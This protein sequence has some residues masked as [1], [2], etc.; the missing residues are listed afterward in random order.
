V[1]IKISTWL[2]CPTFKGFQAGMNDTWTPHLVVVA[3]GSW[4]FPLLFLSTVSDAVVRLFFRL[5][6]ALSAMS[7]L[8]EAARSLGF[9][10]GSALSS[11]IAI[12]RCTWVLDT[13]PFFLF[14]CRYLYHPSLPLFPFLR[15][16]LLLPFSPQ[17]LK[18]GLQAVWHTP[19]ALWHPSTAWSASSGLKRDGSS[20]HTR[21][22]IAKT[23]PASSSAQL[24]DLIA[25]NCSVTPSLS[26]SFVSR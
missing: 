23:I 24:N 3:V 2:I 21:K 25:D 22:Y 8:G 9:H 20:T 10:S 15:G 12:D 19:S 17:S 5:A 16:P 14:P 11:S 7:F 4:I 18:S 6:F 26:R 1:V 13:F